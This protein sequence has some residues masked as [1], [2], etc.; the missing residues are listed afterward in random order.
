MK[1]VYVYKGESLDYKNGTSKTI[2]AGQIV[3]FGTRLGVAGTTILPGET[4]S[5]H[6]VGVFRISK[7]ANEALEE[8]AAVYYSETGI[9]G[10]AAAGDH[11]V[12]YVACT[13]A[14]ADTDVLVKLIG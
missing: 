3:V 1:A 14:V 12:G 5:I 4:G 11:E 9:T 10:T 8:G 7:K 2:E 6:M 13:A